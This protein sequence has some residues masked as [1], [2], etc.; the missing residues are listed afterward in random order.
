MGYA[1][2]NDYFP[3]LEEL[4]EIQHINPSEDTGALKQQDDKNV[5][6]IKSVEIHGTNVVSEGEILSKLN[7]KKGDPYKKEVIQEGLKNI[8]QT[9]YYSC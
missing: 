4:S 6:Y 1:E 2:D 3:S 8:Y 7:F 5:K 9:G